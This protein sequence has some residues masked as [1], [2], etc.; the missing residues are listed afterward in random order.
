VAAGEGLVARLGGV[1]VSTAAVGVLAKGVGVLVAPGLRGVAEARTVDTAQF[2]AATLG[3]AFTLLLLLVVCVGAYELSRERRIATVLRGG[4][5][6]GAALV[7][8]LMRQA[9]HR[10]LPAGTALVMAI[11]AG[12]VAV[13][14]TV[15]VLRHARTR[16][17]GAV[18][19][20]LALSGLLR[21]AAWSVAT[22]AG[23]HAN[24]ML[25]GTSRSVATGAMV[26]QALATLLAAAWLGTRSPWRGRALANAAILGAFVLTYLATREMP[27]T[28]SSV[29]AVLRGSLPTTVGVPTP[30]FE[31]V[32]EFLLPA[33]VLLAGVALVQRAQ[34]PAVL[35]ALGLA[36]LSAGSFDV[37]IHALAI[38][39]A[40]QWAMLA[41]TDD[42]GMWAAMVASR[43]PDAR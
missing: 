41:T 23:E 8:A 5:V 4:V 28:M 27:T 34:P 20:L 36:L 19:G 30:H 15:R 12:L 11:V 43:R 39:A 9:L 21:A 35:T 16:A 3:Y 10:H 42:R 26:F 2:S 7:L 22:L 33:S 1:L 25:Y 17:L 13:V 40:A 31:S 6:L 29:E 38:V 14:A 37:P 18:L 32:A 24:V